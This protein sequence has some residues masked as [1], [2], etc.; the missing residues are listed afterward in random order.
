MRFAT[1]RKHAL[2]LEA[3]TEEP[4]HDYSSFRVRGKIFVTV[5][6][7]RTFIHVFVAEEGRESALQMYPEFLE[8]LYWGRKSVGLRVYLAKAAP[9]A[10]KWLVSEAYEA[11]VRK[12]AGPKTARPG[13]RAVKA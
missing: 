12:D 11:R 13:Q 2:S 3:V 4:H 10:V 7:D 1:V 8:K 6:P 9:A 5:P